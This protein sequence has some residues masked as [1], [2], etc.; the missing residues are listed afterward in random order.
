MSAIAWSLQRWG[1]SHVRLEG[2][3]GRSTGAN[4]ASRRLAEARAETV[5]QRLRDAGMSV[6]AGVATTISSRALY[7]IGG[8]ARVRSVDVMAMAVSP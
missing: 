1:A 2:F 5:A 8:S 4:A 7:A 6:E 3:A